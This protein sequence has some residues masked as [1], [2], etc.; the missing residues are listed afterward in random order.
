MWRK[1]PESKNHDF[2]AGDMDVNIGQRVAAALVKSRTSNE[3][4]LAQ[5]KQLIRAAQHGDT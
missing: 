5:I 1:L 4:L 3:Q 2:P